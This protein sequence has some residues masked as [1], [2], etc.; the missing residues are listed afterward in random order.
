MILAYVAQIFHE[1]DGSLP[2]RKGGNDV[3]VF[4]NPIACQ[5]LGITRVP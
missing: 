4:Q 3:Y 5:G 1:K 2:D